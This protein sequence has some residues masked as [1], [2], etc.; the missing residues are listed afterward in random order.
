MT[1]FAV[2]TV[3]HTLAAMTGVWHDRVEVFELDGTPLGAD[4]RSGTPGP[5]PFDNL[6]YIDFDGERYTQTNVTF[7]GR[8]LHARTFR[9]VLRAGVLVFQRLGPED[10]EHIGA[11]GGP[12]VLFFHPRRVT[13]AWSRYHEPDCIRLLG[14]GTRTRTTLLF[15]D[16]VAIRTLTA[17]GQRLAPTANQRLPWDPRGPSGPVHE[18]SRDTAVFAGGGAS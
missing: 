7:R 3:G 9:G 18:E 5:A 10:P 14:P 6:V 17:H 2:G 13:D 1:A 11:S 4:E 16:G 15:R 12:G 8:P